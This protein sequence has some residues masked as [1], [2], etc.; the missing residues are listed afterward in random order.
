MSSH[1]IGYLPLTIALRLT[2]LGNEYHMARRLMSRAG[3]LEDIIS[4]RRSMAQEEKKIYRIDD[5]ISFRKCSLAD[6]DA[7]THGD[8]TSYYT[9]SRN[10]TEYYHCNQEGI[11]FHCTKHP[12]IELDFVN[13]NY[14][15]TELSCPK[16]GKTVWKGDYS[17]L[18]SRCLKMLNIPI[19]KEAKLIRL[20][21]WYTPEVKKKEKLESNYWVETDVKTDKDG[22]TMIVLYVGNKDSKEKAQFFIKP[23]CQTAN[24]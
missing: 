9:Q 19:F 18:K 16:C 8:C 3:T 14:G 15:D 6:G 10:W 13:N 20:D 21:D 24:Y 7:V 23:E 11:H 22:D 5:N 1:M 2:S 12:E 17:A 4:D